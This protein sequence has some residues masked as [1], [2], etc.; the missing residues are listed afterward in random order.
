MANK[1]ITDVDFVDSLNSNESFFI[2]QN[3]AIKQINK[4]NVIDD[5]VDGIAFDIANGNNIIGVQPLITG[6]AGQFVVIGN[7]GNVTTK[8]ILHAE[9]T[10]F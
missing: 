6:T 4:G 10:N 8:T 5:I 2:N 3:N 1:R 7:D 9:D